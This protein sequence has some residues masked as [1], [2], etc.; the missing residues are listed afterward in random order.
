MKGLSEFLMFWV[1]VSNEYDRIKNGPKAQTSVKLG[2][3]SLIMSISGILSSVGFAVLAYYCFNVDG[4]EGL[5]TF[6]FG[7]ICALAAVA[8]FIR[9]VLASIVYAIYQMRLNKRP[10]GIVS[11]IV[12]VLMVIGTVILIIVAFSVL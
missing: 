4:L 9:L 2:V 1:K 8:F 7:I 10:V 12:S 5:L 3:D 6:I 11:L